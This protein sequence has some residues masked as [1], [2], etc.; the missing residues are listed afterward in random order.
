MGWVKFT[1]KTH[2]APPRAIDCIRFG[3]LDVDMVGFVFGFVDSDVF[4]RD[5]GLD[6]FYSS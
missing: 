3:L 4:M 1:V 2:D 5:F 6:S